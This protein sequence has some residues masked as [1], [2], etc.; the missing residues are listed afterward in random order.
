[1]T[2]KFGSRARNIE[3][4]KEAEKNKQSVVQW[5][6][7]ILPDDEYTLP[8]ILQRNGYRTGF[9]G[10]NH[11]MKV[12]GWKWLPFDTDPTKPEIKKILEKNKKLVQEGFKKMGW[13]FVE[14]VYYRNPEMLGPEALSVHNQDWLTKGG[15]DFIDSQDKE[16]PFFLYFATTLVHWPTEPKRSW[17]ANPLASADGFLEDTLHVQPPRHTIPER[18]KEAGIHGNNS[19]NVLWLDDG[20]GAIMKELEKRGLLENTYVFFL[21]DHGQEA[22][23]T[24][25]QGGIHDPCLIWKKGGFKPGHTIETPVQN[26]DFTPTILDLAGIDWKKYGFDG[27]SFKKVLEG[28]TSAVHKTMYFELG[29]TRAIIKGK[30]K[31]LALRYP[32]YALKWT[33]AERKRI[34]DSINARRRK[35]NQVLAN[36]E[37]DPTKPFSHISLI[38]GGNNAELTSTGKLPGYYDADQ[39]YDLEADPGELHNLAKDPKYK[40]VL[41]DMKKELQKYIDDLP[42][43]FP[44]NKKANK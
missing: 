32:E 36:P 43:G 27:L 23:G 13:E 31:Y 39:L 34:V 19:E 9:V 41:E 2:G 11:V 15:I 40:D 14:S 42:Y 8:K 30:Y 24:L 21:S 16:R 44:L 17:N 12:K 28:D 3:F 5:N 29:Y 10:K 37:G 18:I 38:P 7:D 1:L 20:I 4:K 22:K 25:Y 26:V 6:T 33:M 35:R